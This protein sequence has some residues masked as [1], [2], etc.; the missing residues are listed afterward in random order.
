MADLGAFA[1]AHVLQQ[2]LDQNRC[3]AGFILRHVNAHAFPSEEIRH[4]GKPAIAGLKWM[5]PVGPEGDAHDPRHA[6][7]PHL[8]YGDKVHFFSAAAGTVTALAAKGNDN[9]PLP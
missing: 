6:F 7:V 3:I 8:R 9:R 4:P 2:L 5:K 1:A